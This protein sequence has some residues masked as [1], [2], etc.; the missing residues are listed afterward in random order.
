MCFYFI[1]LCAKTIAFT[2]DF[3][4]NRH[5]FCQQNMEVSGKLEPLEF[6][7]QKH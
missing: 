5:I 4:N 6:E 7:E 2:Q 1:V 3:N